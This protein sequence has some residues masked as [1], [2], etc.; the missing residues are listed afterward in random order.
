MKYKSIYKLCILVFIVLIGVASTFFFR[1]SSQPT[2]P[3]NEIFLIG[4]AIKKVTKEK[5][6]AVIRPILENIKGDKDYSPITIDY[7]FDKSLLP[8]EIVAPT[9]LWHDKLENSDRWLIHISFEGMPNNIYALTAGKQ[10]E[11]EIDPEAVS[12]A[13]ENYK[14]S[15]YDTTA[16]AWSPDEPT[17]QII[18]KNS[19]GRYAV[20]TVYGLNSRENN[21]VLSTAWIK[22]KTSR[23]LVGAPI[24]YRDV[25]LMPSETEEG[26]IKPIDEGALP[27]IAWRLRDISKPSDRR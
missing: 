8:P 1:K 23:D 21:Q 22:L 17:W 16:K 26:Q 18:K 4:P 13:N 7:P 5:P 6:S 15:D 2:A 19:V 20:V 25:P 3:E 27:L 14:P 10:S 12:P 11:P 9:F 24:F